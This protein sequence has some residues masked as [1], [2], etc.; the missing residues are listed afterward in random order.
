MIE[1]SEDHPLRITVEDRVATIT[2]HRPE[3]RNAI[4]PAMRRGIQSSFADL[5]ADDGVDVLVL[6]GAD[7]AFCEIGRAH[8]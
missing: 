4:D 3:V 6:T 5:E 1:P 8:V 7:P 2:L